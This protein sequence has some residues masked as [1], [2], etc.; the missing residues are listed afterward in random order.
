MNSTGADVPD[1]GVRPSR[2][3]QVLA[4]IFATACLVWVFHDVHPHQL[5]VTVS[6]ANWWFVALAIIIDVLTYV[7][8]GM[9]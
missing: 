2:V 1:E 9:R 7:L 4:Y 5:L 3:K 8:Q 6:I